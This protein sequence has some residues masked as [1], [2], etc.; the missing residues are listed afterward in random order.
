ML[1]H[2]VKCFFFYLNFA[3]KQVISFQK[4]PA[5]KTIPENDIAILET[6]PV[7]ELGFVPVC[8]STDS[9][10]SPGDR[11]TIVSWAP[12]NTETYE[13]E[14]KSAQSSVVRNALC[15]R[16]VEIDVPSHS[17]CLNQGTNDAWFCRGDS[18]GSFMIRKGRYWYLRGIVSTGATVDGDC[19]VA[20]ST[21]FTNVAK[22]HDFISGE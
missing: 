21:I 22:F 8:L 19:K 18:G 5:Y 9:S 1:W 7:H 20:K 14:L 3:E 13:L 11:G 10:A 16:D 12:E 4:H 15:E 6:E 2:V 17:F